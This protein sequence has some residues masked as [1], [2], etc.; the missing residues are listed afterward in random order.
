[1]HYIYLYN[2]PVFKFE[3]KTFITT[4]MRCFFMYIHLL[5]CICAFSDQSL[6][7]KYINFTLIWGPYISKIWLG[8]LKLHET[9]P[10]ELFIASR[11]LF[12]QYLNVAFVFLCMKEQ[13]ME[14]ERERDKKEKG[15]VPLRDED[16]WLI[17]HSP[18]CWWWGL[19]WGRNR[20]P[21]LAMSSSFMAGK[22]RKS[23]A[24]KS[25]VCVL[26]TFCLLVPDSMLHLHLSEFNHQSRVNTHCTRRC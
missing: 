23:E 24:I 16:S 20:D 13:R 12:Q 18:I 3:L 8:L 11:S 5:V 2:S 6:L 19:W 25:A 10:E 22:K 15:W 1:M 14:I 4:T 17:A 21:F 26:L 9:D 7:F